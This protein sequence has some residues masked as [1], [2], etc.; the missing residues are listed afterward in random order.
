MRNVATHA[1]GNQP[2][3]SGVGVVGYKRFKCGCDDVGIRSTDD[4][5][6]HILYGKIEGI[7]DLVTF[8]S[9]NSNEIVDEFHS[10]VD[11][12]LAFCE[13]VGKSPDKEYRGVFNVRVKPE[14]HRKLAEEAIKRGTSLNFLTEQALAKFLG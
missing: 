5:E 13:S 2:D 14:L 12:Y 9:E 11:D 1:T 3:R 7:I 8:E 6:S 4:T 10:A